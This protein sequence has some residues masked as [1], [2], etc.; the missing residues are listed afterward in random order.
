M[1][2][3][4]YA[5]QSVEKAITILKAF[6]HDKPE[7]GVSELAR[8]LG[9]HKSTVSRLM[10]TL[11]KGGLLTRNTESE[12]YRLGVELIG[13]AAHVISYLDLREVARPLLRDLAQSCQET[14]NLVVLDGSQ[15]VNLEQFV[16]PER[17]VKN[18]GWVGKRMP[19]HCTAAGKV[20]LAH[21]PPSRLDRTLPAELACFTPHTVTSPDDLRRELSL[22]L[23]QGYATVTEEMEVGLNAV[24]VPVF[25]HAGRVQSSITVAGPAYRVTADRYPTYAQALRT[26][27]ADISRR[28][29]NR[30]VWTM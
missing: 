21:L 19:I 18:I 6:G 25:D 9:W 24:A 1:E 10:A 29:G 28:L 30:D 17:L 3:Q 8:H 7:W 22:I 4:P 14:V 23:R 13:L 15:V 5:I 20:L 2:S 12:P 26:T 16:P 27:A 11:E